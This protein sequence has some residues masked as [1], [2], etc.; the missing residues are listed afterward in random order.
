MMMMMLII[1]VVVVVIFHCKT[2][3]LTVVTATCIQ[4]YR[5]FKYNRL[6]QEITMLSIFVRLSRM[7]CNKLK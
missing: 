7:E 4:M 5:T 6:C 1:I 3:S 2:F